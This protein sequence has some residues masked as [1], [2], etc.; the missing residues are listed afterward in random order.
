M[1][2]PSRA[3]LAGH[4]LDVAPTLLGCTIET[5]DVAVRITEV[6][7]YSGLGLDPASHAHRGPTPRTQVMFGPPGHAYV[8]FS[9][10]MHWCVNVVTGPQGQASAVL[11][12]GG[13]V[14]R[15]AAVARARR[16]AARADVELARGPARLCAAL[17]LDGASSGLDLLDAASPVRL[18]RGD[19]QD[20]PSVVRSGPRVGV[21]QAADRPWRFWLDGEATVSRYR[22][23]VR[24]T[25]E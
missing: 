3:Q 8:Y 15:G 17:G 16:P 19:L 24:R 20:D 21:S 13:S 4:V 22:A 1:P 10:G 23:S 11:L 5:D 25:P 9:Y 6:E 12:R 7:A 14:G 18:V 2:S